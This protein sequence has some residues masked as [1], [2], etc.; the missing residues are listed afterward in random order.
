M[1]RLYRVFFLQNIYGRRFW[2]APR[3]RRSGERSPGFPSRFAKWNLHP[4]FCTFCRIWFQMRFF[5]LCI[6]PGWVLFRLHLH[7]IVMKTYFKQLYLCQ[8]AA[9]ARSPAV[10]RTYGGSR[11]LHIDPLVWPDFPLISESGTEWHTVFCNVPGHCA[12]LCIRCCHFSAWLSLSSLMRCVPASKYFKPKE[13]HVCIFFLHISVSD[14]PGH[15]VSI[16]TLKLLTVFSL[17]VKS[18]TTTKTISARWDSFRTIPDESPRNPNNKCC[19]VRFQ[20]SISF[21]L[22]S[23]MPQECSFSFSLLTL[24]T[25]LAWNPLRI[26]DL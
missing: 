7:L 5:Q 9:L 24:N 8:M 10:S 19:Q 25:T 12:C 13:L 22:Y 23:I 4:R 2:R 6:Q 14:P 21:S 1:N 18:V 20:R 11:A 15:L 3:L 17:I 26:T 16:R